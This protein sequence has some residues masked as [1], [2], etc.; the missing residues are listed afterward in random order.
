MQTLTERALALT[1]EHGERDHQAYDLRLLGE[2]A[3]AEASYQ[4]A[5]TLAGELGMHP[6]LWPIATSA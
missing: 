3:P 4:E 5:H 6:L 1:H 2:I